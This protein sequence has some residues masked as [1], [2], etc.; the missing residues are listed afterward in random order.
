M[1]LYI[2][3]FKRAQWFGAACRD[4]KSRVRFPPSFYWIF[5]LKNSK[6]LNLPPIYKINY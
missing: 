1:Y 3:Y 4:L 5:K 2:N 6:Y